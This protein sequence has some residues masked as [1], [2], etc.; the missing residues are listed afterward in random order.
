MGK[1][2]ESKVQSTEC[3]LLFKIHYTK[4]F[5]DWKFVLQGTH[6]LCRQ[7]EDKANATQ[8][9]QT[10]VEIQLATS[11]F[12]ID[13]KLLHKNHTYTYNLASASTMNDGM[14]VNE[15]EY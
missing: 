15:N 9:S 10:M 3:G 1:S 5:L 8:L 13:S 14:K 6:P 7:V 4:Y 11:L 2:S 12:H